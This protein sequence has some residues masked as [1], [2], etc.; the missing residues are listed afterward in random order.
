MSMMSSQGDPVAGAADARDLRD[1]YSA[2]VQAS[3]QGD[4]A[5]CAGLL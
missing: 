1:G 5:R 2:I 3:D 4:V